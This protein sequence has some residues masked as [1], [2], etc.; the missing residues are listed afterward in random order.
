VTTYD[1]DRDA[2]EAETKRQE[3]ASTANL[4]GIVAGRR[5]VAKGLLAPDG[6]GSPAQ[7]VKDAWKPVTNRRRTV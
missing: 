1:P 4:E 7:D 2:I 3:A 6:P 5:R